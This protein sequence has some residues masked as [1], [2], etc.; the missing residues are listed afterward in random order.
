LGSCRKSRIKSGE[1]VEFSVPAFNKVLYLVNICWSQ[2][3]PIIDSILDIFPYLVNSD[4]VNKLH[5]L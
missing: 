2:P 1:M 5:L 4:I 3:K